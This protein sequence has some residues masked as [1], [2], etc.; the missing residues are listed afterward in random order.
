ML[1]HIHPY[2]RGTCKRLPYILRRANTVRATSRD[3]LTVYNSARQ[4]LT[5]SKTGNLLQVP[6]RSWHRRRQ[7]WSLLQLP[8]GLGD[9]LADCLRVSSRCPAGLGDT[10]APSGSLLHVSRRSWHHRRLSVSLLQVPRRSGRL[11][12]T[13]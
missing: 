13:V 10:L 2:R 6:R 1:T 5:P 11:S 9:C 4:S 12:G 3:S 7:S 8:A